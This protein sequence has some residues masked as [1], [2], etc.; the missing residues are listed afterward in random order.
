MLK[1]IFDSTGCRNKVSRHSDWE[2]ASSTVLRGLGSV[3]IAVEDG[4]FSD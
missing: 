1:E 4:K 2:L 3:K